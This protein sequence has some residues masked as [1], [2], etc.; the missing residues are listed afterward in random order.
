M[1]MPQRGSGPDGAER[2][3]LRE[4]RL[5]ALGIPS[6][7]QGQKLVDVI[8]YSP[9]KNWLYLIEAVHSSN[10]LTPQRH[11]LLRQALDKATASRIYV[12]AFHGRRDFR[13]WA[14]DISWET[15]VWLANEPD[16]M[17]HFNGDRFMGPHEGD[18]ASL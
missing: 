6:F 5:R 13:K 7:L 1:L 3:I 14:A 12:T 4:D 18:E 17:I 10:P 16:H 8:A 9:S 15:E 2:K 11:I